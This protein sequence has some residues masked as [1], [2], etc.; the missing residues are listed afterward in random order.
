MAA[1]PP[2]PT[3]LLR[4]AVESGRVHSGYLLSGDREAALAAATQFARALV[5]RSSAER[6]CEDCQDCAR[7]AGSAASA[8]NEPVEIDG[9]GKRGPLFRHIGDH[10]DLFWIDRG[11]DSTRV[12]IGQIRAIQSALQLG[13]YEGGRRVAVIADA[14][15][16][17]IAAQNALLRLLEE[18]PNDTTLVLVTASAAGLVVTIRSRCQRVVFPVPAA[19]PIRSEDAP[20]EVRA[21]AARLDRAATAGLPDLLD[22][23][24]EFRGERASAAERVQGL[25]ATG[26]E[27]LRERTTAAA[28]AGR[29]DLRGELDA[30]RALQACRKDL[31]QRN[32]NPQM[33]AERA[34]FALR[35]A[36]GA[37]R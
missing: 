25:L 29:R 27:W 6:P 28:S 5:C 19:T 32:A 16:L 14:E 31:S 26:S 23:A 12:R 17:N 20:E 3:T 18:P 10:P 34:L 35:A 21:T 22:W 36:A 13:S 1:A 33:V 4:R 30:F 7:S 9:T 24:E 37:A 11:S 15:W 8:A 2:D